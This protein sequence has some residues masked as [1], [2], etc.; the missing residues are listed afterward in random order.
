MKKNLLWR[1]ICSFWREP[2]TKSRRPEKKT[3]EKRL[4]WNLNWFCSGER[5]CAFTRLRHIVYCLLPEAGF[6]VCRFMSKVFHY[7]S[8]FGMTASSSTSTSSSVHRSPLRFC[9]FR[10]CKV[11]KPNLLVCAKKLFQWNAATAS[12]NNGTAILIW[13]CK[14]SSNIDNHLVDAGRSECPPEST[15]T[16]WTLDSDEIT[17]WNWIEL[18]CAAFFSAFFDAEWLLVHAV[19][20][21]SIPI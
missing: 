7:F 9:P 2:N 21:H 12:N 3:T 5:V 4:N 10:S 11:Q 6:C 14:W 18:I 1:K 8:V 17:Y 16:E 15:T 20:V 19:P 13:I